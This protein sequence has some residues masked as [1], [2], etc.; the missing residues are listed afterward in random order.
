MRDRPKLLTQITAAAVLAAAMRGAIEAVKVGQV[1]FREIIEAASAPDTVT[2]RRRMA[3]HRSFVRNVSGRKG[4]RTRRKKHRGPKPVRF[5][6]KTRVRR[7]RARKRG[8][9]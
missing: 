3:Q 9:A 1:G 5:W 7:I 8:R 2:R 6:R 4:D